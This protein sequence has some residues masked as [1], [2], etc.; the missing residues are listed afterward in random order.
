MKRHSA[1]L[2]TQQIFSLLAACFSLML[3]DRI[4]YATLSCF[5]YSIVD[6]PLCV[7]SHSASSKR[8]SILVHHVLLLISVVAFYCSDPIHIPR[9]KLQAQLLVALEI[10]TP[11]VIMHNFIPTIITTKVRNIAWAIVRIPCSIAIMLLCW[12]EPAPYIRALSMSFVCLTM[13]WTMGNTPVGHVCSLISYVNPIYE[14]LNPI[15]G[16]NL[17]LCTLSLIGSAMF[18]LFDR[19]NLDQTILSI[20]PM[21]GMG[22]RKWYFIVFAFIMVYLLTTRNVYIGQRLPN[23]MVT[24]QVI[25]STC[26]Y[27]NMALKISILSFYAPLLCIVVSGGPK[28]CSYS[29][30]VVWHVCACGLLASLIQIDKTH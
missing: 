23:I 30:K 26:A 1:L 10:T 22:V 13:A 20:Y 3:I 17:I 5:F 19:R 18:Y 21:F 15:S 4:E 29:V 16:M 2:I 8:T 12:Y 28:R 6:I 14:S 11:F 27:T 9:R 7:M 24:A 25:Y